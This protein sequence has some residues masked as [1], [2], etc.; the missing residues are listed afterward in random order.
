MNVIHLIQKKHKQNNILHNSHSHLSDLLSDEPALRKSLFTC[1]LLICCTFLY[2]CTNDITKTHDTFKELC[3]SSGGQWLEGYLCKCPNS[4]VCAKG[5]TCITGVCANNICSA[6]EEGKT[7]CT[8]DDDKVGHKQI[9]KNNQWISDNPPSCEGNSCNKEKTDCG[10]CHND[11]IK[12]D[13]S[14]G[15]AMRKQCTDGEWKDQVECRN[16]SCNLYKDKRDKDKTDCGECQNGTH[17]CVDGELQN[18][19]NGSWTKSG[20]CAFRECKPDGKTCADCA[21]GSTKC[22]PGNSGDNTKKMPY[23]TFVFSV[24]GQ[25]HGRIVIPLN[26][27]IPNAQY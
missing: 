5:V 18:C 12:C 10:D 22:T 17:R 13:E 7:R 4:G 24:N 25:I 14:S 11:E 1:I 16:V 2:S 6:T 20:D 15:K 23:I 9:C 27:K 3:E 8:D 19:Q 21:S 26:A